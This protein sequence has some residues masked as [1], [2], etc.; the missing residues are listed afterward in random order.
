[1]GWKVGWLSTVQGYN[2]LDPCILYTCLDI[3]TTMPRGRPPKRKSDDT[4][5][6]TSESTTGANSINDK[7]DIKYNSKHNNNNDSNNS[8]KRARRSLGNNKENDNA[9][10]QPD[11]P[12]IPQSSTTIVQLP[13][14]NIIQSIK[15]PYTGYESYVTV[16]VHFNKSPATDTDIEPDMLSILIIPTPYNISLQSSPPLYTPLPLSSIYM[17]PFCA[18]NRIRV[19]QSNRIV[20]GEKGYRSIRATHGITTGYMYYEICI[21]SRQ[22]NICELQ[23]IPLSSEP[24]VRVGWSSEKHDIDT[25]I[26]YD[27]YSYN[28]ADK[29]LKFHEACM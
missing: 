17:S 11:I 21:K 25:P 29:G 10:H 22:Y 18:G 12:S 14:P 20:Y 6:I 27:R 19:D 1:M 5:S 13:V 24:H 15:Q 3:N 16:F 4:D 9:S 26:G 28:Y 8:N 2:Q 7:N 23:N